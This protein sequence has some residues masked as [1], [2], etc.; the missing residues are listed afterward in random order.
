MTDFAKLYD[1]LGHKFK[2]QDLLITALRHPSL[3]YSKQK[4]CNNY[5]RLELL[6]DAVLSLIIIDL[7]FKK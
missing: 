1:I 4:K 7:L 2:N 5:E 3:C 6:G